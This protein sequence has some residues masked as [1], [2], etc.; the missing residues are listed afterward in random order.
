MGSGTNGCPGVFLTCNALLPAVY[1]QFICITRHCIWLLL[2]DGLKPERTKSQSKRLLSTRLLSDHPPDILAK[3]APA[4]LMAKQA[5][6]D[7]SQSGA[8]EAWASET[9]AVILNALPTISKS[10]PSSQ[11]TSTAIQ[12]ASIHLTSGSAIFTNVVDFGGGGFGNASFLRVTKG[13]GH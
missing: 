6:V 3:R 10:L 12:F 13:N 2:L 1:V 4:F 7:P 8:A 11:C 5:E 9:L